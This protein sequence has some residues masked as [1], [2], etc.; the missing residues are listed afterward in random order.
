MADQMPSAPTSSDARAVRP[1]AKTA[2]TPSS[3]A[4]ASYNRSRP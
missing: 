3:A 1:P 2:R 4:T